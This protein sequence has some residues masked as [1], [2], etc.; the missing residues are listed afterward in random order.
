MAKIETRKDVLTLSGIKVEVERRGRGK[1]LLLLHGEEALE[2]D[3]QV[4]DELASRFEVIIPSPPGYG[5]SDRPLWLSNPHDLAF[6][7]HDL[8]RE[9]K[10][11]DAVVLGFSV[12]G[13]IAAEMATIDDGFMAKLVLVDPVGIKLGGPTDRDIADIWL[14]HP[15]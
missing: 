13:W 8:V 10:L 14:L 9:L 15:D 7:M 4:V 6:V 11:Q 5:G 12:G 2:T 1:P 3:C